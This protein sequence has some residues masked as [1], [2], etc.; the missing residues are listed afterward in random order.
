MQA[1]ASDVSAGLTLADIDV[2][3]A[4]WEDEYIVQTQD[5]ERG[6]VSDLSYVIGCLSSP[7]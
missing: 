1:F 6:D 2:V 7:G 4:H 5:G 3:T